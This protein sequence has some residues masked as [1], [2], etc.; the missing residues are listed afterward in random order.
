MGEKK[1]PSAHD[2]A[3][4]VALLISPLALL[5]FG[6]VVWLVL[7]LEKVM[8]RDQLG[9]HIGVIML[10]AVVWVSVYLS[11]H[12]HIKKREEEINRLKGQLQIKQDSIVWLTARVDETTQE[13][14]AG[15]KRITKL[16]KNMEWL[17]VVFFEEIVI[18]CKRLRE[19][20]ESLAMNDWAREARKA[21]VRRLIGLIMKE[22]VDVSTFMEWFPDPKVIKDVIDEDIGTP[23]QAFHRQLLPW[24]Q[25]LIRHVNPLSNPNNAGKYPK[26]NQI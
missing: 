3:L 9:M 6:H 12:W 24:E 1:N 18:L 23:T 11:I 17:H 4:K 26:E 7:S 8:T 21:W 10:D 5:I 25:Q 22:I 2:R 13:I 14:I 20:M 15:E 19:P 16:T